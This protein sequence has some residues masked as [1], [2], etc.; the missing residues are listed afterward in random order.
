MSQFAFVFAGRAGLDSANVRNHVLRI[1]EV[2]LRVREAQ[3]ILDGLGFPRV[4]LFGSIS[5][6]DETFLRNIRMKSL[7]AAVVQV[8]LFDRLRKAALGRSP[9]ILVG[10]VNGDSALATAIGRQSFEEMVRGSAAVDTLRP[11]PSLAERLSLVTVA[12]PAPLLAGVSLAEYEAV[13]L[14]PGTREFETIQSGQMDLSKLLKALVEGRGVR[15][16]VNIGPVGLV[17][18]E[19]W[20]IEEIEVIDSIELDPML[21]WFWKA[22]RPEPKNLAN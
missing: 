5:S 9:E 21:S 1:P 19:R 15:G 6:D 11:A 12:S 14:S 3:S 4:D 16:F 18:R 13:A 20:G 17:P 10:V 7:S 2:S 8:G 22:I